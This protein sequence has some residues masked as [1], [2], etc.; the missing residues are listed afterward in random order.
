MEPTLTQKTG[1][2]ADFRLSLLALIDRLF[3]PEEASRLERRLDE[4]K[5][6]PLGIV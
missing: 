5:A 3:G 6:P 2:A 4:E 1:S